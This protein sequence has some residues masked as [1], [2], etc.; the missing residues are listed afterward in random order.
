MALGGVDYNVYCRAYLGAD[1]RVS[2][3]PL[4]AAADLCILPLRVPA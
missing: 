1:F 4:G 3:P 2:L